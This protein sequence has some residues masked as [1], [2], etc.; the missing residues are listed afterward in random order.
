MKSIESAIEDYK[1][2]NKAINYIVD[3]LDARRIHKIMECLDWHWSGFDDI[4][5]EF[6]IRQQARKLLEQL[7]FNDLSSL[8]TG[9]FRVEKLKDGDVDYYAI[10]FVVDSV[11]SFSVSNCNEK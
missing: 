7:V 1:Q 6:E 8:E 3:Q 10:S 4:A 2:K 11:D 9:G 5:D